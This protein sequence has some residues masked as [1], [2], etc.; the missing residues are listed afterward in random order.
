VSG[1]SFGA[2]AAVTPFRATDF[3]E[4]SFDYRIQPGVQVNLYVYANRQWH[5]VQLCADEPESGATP[6]LGRIEGV[7]RDEQW[8]HAKFDLLSP[9][10]GLYPEL[11]MFTVKYVAFAAPEESY[12]RCG[13]G[14]NHRGATYWV[15]NFGIGAPTP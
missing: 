9:L 10:K 7:Q 12:A 2:Y 11:K 3:P 13:I 15:D 8:H 4:L 14:G 6:L 1:G 5:A